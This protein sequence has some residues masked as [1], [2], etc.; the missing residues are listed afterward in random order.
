MHLGL[1]ENNHDFPTRFIDIPPSSP[2]SIRTLL[3][4]RSILHRQ[5]S[6]LRRLQRERH[7][8]LRVL[9]RDQ[10]HVRRHKA[11][12][13]CFEGHEFLHVFV[14]EAFCDRHRIIVEAADLQSCDDRLSVRLDRFRLLSSVA[15][16]MHTLRERGVLSIDRKNVPARAQTAGLERKLRR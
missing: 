10:A 7:L 16:D 15:C 8:R 3:R 13:R 2:P 6:H 1:A 11:F 5:L 14:R 4:V 9:F 12:G